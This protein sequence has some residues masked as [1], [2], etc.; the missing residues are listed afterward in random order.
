MCT[1]F[2]SAIALALL[3][4]LAGCGD[5]LISVST[6]GRIQVA[7]NTTGLD[8]D[9]DGFSVSVDG[10]TEQFLEASGTVT[11]TNLSTG[12]HSIRLSGL[13]ENCRVD[14]ANP[15]SVVVASDGTAQVAFEVRCVR[16]TTG[17]F[18]VEV[19]TTGDPIDPDGYQLSVA[20]V[21]ARDIGTSARE[22]FAGLT[23]GVHLITLKDVDAPCAVVGGNPQ[24]FTVVPG[25]TVAV[26]LAVACGGAGA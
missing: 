9:T 5:T 20:G 15:R 23:P 22:T 24:P 21:A 25:K 14:G 8:T 4:P 18:L 26:R 7:V 19:T 16:A 6:D 10:G 17:G 13:A 1:R 3:A 2:A 11:L 12:A